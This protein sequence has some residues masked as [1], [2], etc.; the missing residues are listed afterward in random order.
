MGKELFRTEDEYGSIVVTERNAKRILSF[1]STMEQSCIYVSKPYY[2]AHEYTQIMLLGLIFVEAKH[3]TML[4][5]G[6]G[7][8]VYCLHHYFKSMNLQ[9]V[10]LRY[11]VIDIAYEWFLLPKE[12]QVKVSCS[13]AYEYLQHTKTRSTDLI[14]SDLYESNGMSGL[15]EQAGFIDACHRT[16]TDNGRLILN[17]HT[18]PEAELSLMHRIHNS[19]ETVWVCNV[20]DGNWI[21]FCDKKPSLFD[22]ATLDF[23]AQA[24]VDQVRM[25]LMYYYR[26]MKL[27]S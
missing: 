27:I 5:L 17:F 2:L 18:D 19:F 16:L 3:I 15:Q 20:I 22:K 7:G 1:G 13:D 12:L 21:L 25:P 24:L 4:G 6:G 8:L 14:F 11:A 26:N 10:E 23:R 9:I